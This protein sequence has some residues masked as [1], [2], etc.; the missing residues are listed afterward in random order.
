[1]SIYRSIYKS[2]FKWQDCIHDCVFL[3]Y[4]KEIWISACFFEGHF[5]LF[6]SFSWRPYLE[7]CS[8]LCAQ[9]DIPACLRLLLLTP[10]TA[11]SI[12]FKMSWHMYAQ[13][14]ELLAGPLS[15]AGWQSI[16]TTSSLLLPL[17]TSRY[18]LLVKNI[19]TH[20][21]ER[22]PF[23]WYFDKLLGFLCRRRKGLPGGER[24]FIKARVN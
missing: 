24:R 17:S 22:L 10:F 2:I 21:R 5:C 20:T 3:N 15:R 13:W 7:P 6:L 12:P 4:K 18:F 1:M 23:F 16:T 8:F 9:L 14:F 11:A 19:H